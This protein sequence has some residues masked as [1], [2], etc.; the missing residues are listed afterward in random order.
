M[1]WLLSLVFFA[2]MNTLMLVLAA[3]EI[4]ET[5]E[6]VE[7]LYVAQIVIIAAFA[8]IEERRREQ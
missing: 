8:I 3:L 1:V 6:R 5:Q 4:G 2:T 7:S